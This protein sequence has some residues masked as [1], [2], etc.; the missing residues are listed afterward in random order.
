M[1]TAFFWLPVAH[2]HLGETC[3]MYTSVLGFDACENCGHTSCES[4]RSFASS[5]QHVFT[6]CCDRGANRKLPPVMKDAMVI[7]FGT[8][9]AFSCLAEA[10]R[11]AC[12]SS[13]AIPGRRYAAVGVLRYFISDS[14]CMS[15]ITQS[16]STITTCTIEPMQQDTE[17]HNSE[18]HIMMVSYAPVV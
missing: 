9:H 13:T 15:N 10:S 7:S 8:P 4:A 17:Q 1:S 12:T 18:V 16:R 3:Q 2:D 6:T 11:S 5:L 14:A